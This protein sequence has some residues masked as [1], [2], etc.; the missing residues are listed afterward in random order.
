MYISKINKRHY[1]YDYTS[2]VSEKGINKINRAYSKKGVRYV[3]KAKAWEVL[4]NKLFKWTPKHYKNLGE[5]LND[6]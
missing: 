6:S 3:R 4:L 1:W 2:F 5:F